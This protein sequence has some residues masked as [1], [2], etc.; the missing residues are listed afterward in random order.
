MSSLSYIRTHQFHLEIIE[1]CFIR[2]MIEDANANPLSNDTQSLPLKFHQY[3]SSI[4][5]GFVSLKPTPSSQQDINWIKLVSTT[6]YILH[7]R[8]LYG[9]IG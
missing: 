9:I 2:H 3:F 7:H 8:S 5:S 1:V 6:H 4:F